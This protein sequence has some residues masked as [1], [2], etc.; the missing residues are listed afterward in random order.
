MTLKTQ[1]A[2]LLPDVMVTCN[3]EDLE[4]S[5]TYIEFPC[6]VIEVLSPSTTKEDRGE[7]FLYYTNC[8][9]I[10]E[11]VLVSQ[12]KLLVEIYTRNG[13]KWEYCAYTRGTQIELKSIGLI[14]PIEKLYQKAILA[15]HKPL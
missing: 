14:F 8:P 10:Q 12:D 6:L 2:C 7:K 13:L 15:P 9:S 5:K 3:S 4:E 1:D 11:Y